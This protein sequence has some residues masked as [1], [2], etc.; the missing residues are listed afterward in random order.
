DEGWI[1]V[2]AEDEAHPLRVPPIDVGGQREVGV[3]PQEDVREASSPTELDGFV[4]EN[5]SPLRRRAIAAPVEEPERLAGVRQR[6]EQGVIA[7]R[8]LV[9]QVHALLALAERGDVRAVRV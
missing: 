6:H 4:E 1:R 2:V 7:P 3:P 5:V 8:A 9:V